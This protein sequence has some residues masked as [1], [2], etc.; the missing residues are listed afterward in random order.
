MKILIEN[1]KIKYG[2]IMMLITLFHIN[3]AAQL[4][5]VNA[6]YYANEYLINSAMAGKTK[7]FNGYVGYRK[8]LSSFAS[9]AQSQLLTADYGFDGKSGVGLKIFN[10]QSGLLKE[11]AI[12]GTYAYHLPLTQERKLSFGLSV[13]YTTQNLNSGDLSGDADDPD[14]LDLEQREGIF[15]SDFGIA[16]SSETFNVQLAIPNLIHTLKN[17]MN[18]GVNYTTFFSSISYKFKTEIGALEPMLVYRGV[19][20]MNGI[21]DFGANFILNSSRSSQFN[22]M[23]LYQ[24]SKNATLGVGV[25]LNKKL[26][27]NTSYTIATSGLNSYSNGDFELGVGIKL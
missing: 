2:L 4:K 27:F 25:L 23:A 8:Q 10:D 24:G 26:S 18:N 13:N 1:S 14:V 3:S 12:T 7:G 15:D 6:I 22:V 11:T 16:Y 20:G 19:K 9:A 17:D 21:V 5:P